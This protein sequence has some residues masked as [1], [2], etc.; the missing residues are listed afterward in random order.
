SLREERLGGSPLHSS[1]V[2]RTAR[3]T[4]SMS[5]I[6][7]LSATFLP[8]RCG[9]GRHR[10]LCFNVTVYCKRCASMEKICPSFG[11]ET[12]PPALLGERRYW[13]PLALYGCRAW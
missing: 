7:T 5:A 4:I 13:D 10:T 8:S 1:R 3:E 12:P 2:Q 9:F 11:R 6:I